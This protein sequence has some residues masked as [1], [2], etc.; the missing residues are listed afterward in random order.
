MSAK[1]KHF[2]L[3]KDYQGCELVKFIEI[4]KMF[5]CAKLATL[6]TNQFKIIYNRHNGP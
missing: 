3:S 2:N 5:E 1:N 6:Q 4:T